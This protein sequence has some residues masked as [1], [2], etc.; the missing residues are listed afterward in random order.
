L[1]IPD[2]LFT[3]TAAYRSNHRNEDILALKGLCHEMNNFL[4]S[5]VLGKILRFQRAARSA[6]LRRERPVSGG[7]PAP[8]RSS[9]PPPAQRPTSRSAAP[10]AASAHPPSAPS[11][12]RPRRRTAPP[13]H[14]HSSSSNSSS[15]SSC[16]QI[17]TGGPPVL[18]ELAAADFPIRGR[19]GGQVQLPPQPPAQLGPAALRQPPTAGRGLFTF[20]SENRK[21]HPPLPI[22]LLRRHGRRAMNR[23]GRLVGSPW[24]PVATHRRRQ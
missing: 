19:H 23:P 24:R 9:F 5:P 10:A 4:T 7:G 18:R 11:P 8:R 2:N 12:P 14:N 22:L 13:N 3:I 20:P 15:H 1:H 16:R 21:Q 17:S 6:S